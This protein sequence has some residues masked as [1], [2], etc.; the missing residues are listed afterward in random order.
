[1]KEKRVNSPKTSAKTALLLIDLV[2]DFSFEDGDKL[3]KQTKKVIDP[4]AA[5]TSKARSLNIPVVYVNDNFGK[6]SE[7]FQSQVKRI[8]DTSDRGREIVE[9]ILP[10]ESDLYVLKPQRSGFYETPLS[11][12]LESMGITSLIL[13]GITTDICVLFTAHDA[14]MRGFSLVLPSDCTAAVK[15]GH[16]NQALELIERVAK[17]DIRPSNQLEDIW[18]R[19]KNKK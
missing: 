17:A 4:I 7:D 6:W 9:P 12:L 2:S 16:R 13:A 5:L 11:V 10:Q 18:D 15:E 14:Y 19:A 8:I 3:W 1:M